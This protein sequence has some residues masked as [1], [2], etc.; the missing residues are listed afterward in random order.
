[1]NK[2]GGVFLYDSLDKENPTDKKVIQ[3]V[4]DYKIY[5][6]LLLAI[7]LL[8][9]LLLAIHSY[10]LS[11]LDNYRI[12]LQWFGWA[13]VGTMY[14]CIVVSFIGATVCML[15]YLFTVIRTRGLINLMEYQAHISQLPAI[16]KD[17]MLVQRERASKSI[18]AGVQNLTYSPHS[19]I[20]HAPPVIEHPTEHKELEDLLLDTSLQGLHTRGLI[21][22][23]G[24]SI[25]LGF[26]DE[27]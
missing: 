15:L 19:D 17:F 18:F 11:L 8:V 1:M 21:A 4:L 22:R 3:P 10:A 14:L 20:A 6:V 12:A 26:T 13:I 25:L 24:N 7:F 16:A 23:S 5:L 27:T 2:H 9:M